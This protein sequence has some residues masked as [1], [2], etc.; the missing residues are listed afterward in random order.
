MVFGATKVT[1]SGS[2]CG[3]EN[4]GQPS[5]EDMGQFDATYAELGT[6]DY[7]WFGQTDRASKATLTELNTVVRF[8]DQDDFDPD[9]SIPE[10]NRLVT[11]TLMSTSL[12]GNTN[13][14]APTGMKAYLSVVRWITQATPMV[15]L[16]S[17]RKSTNH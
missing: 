11:Q 3:S 5:P 14:Q 10:D 9:S 8:C 7:W 2:E 17:C 4:G 16:A 12:S 15:V 1:T 6:I 13:L